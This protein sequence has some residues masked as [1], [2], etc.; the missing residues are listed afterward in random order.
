MSELSSY[1]MHP[2]ESATSFQGAT[3]TSVK[4]A[5]T[6]PYSIAAVRAH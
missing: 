6:F 4:M 5:E 2:R 1:T 3:F